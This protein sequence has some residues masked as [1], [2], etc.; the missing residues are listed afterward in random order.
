MHL[1]VNWSIKPLPYDV[2]YNNR[3]EYVT[4]KKAILST[5]LASF[6]QID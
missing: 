2:K 3:D 5:L 6:T 4:N 1:S